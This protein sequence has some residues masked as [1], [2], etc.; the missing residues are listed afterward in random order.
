MVGSR[1]ASLVIIAT[2]VIVVGVASGAF[3]F[4]DRWLPPSQTTEGTTSG[5]PHAADRAARQNSHLPVSITLSPQAQRNLGLTT[6]PV[7]ITDAW[8]KLVVPGQLVER[9]GH[10][11]RNVTAPLT[12]VIRELFVHPNQLVH[13][14][15]LLAELELTGD[16]LATAQAD[17]LAIVRD[18][19]I[20][21][22]EQ[23]RIGKLVAEGSLPEKNRLQLEY[24]YKRLESQHQSKVQALQVLGLSPAQVEQITT[25]K[26]L[27]RTFRI[28]VPPFSSEEKSHVHDADPPA[29]AKVPEAAAH[30]GHNHAP[31]AAAPPIATVPAEPM[32]KPGHAPPMGS[33][34]Q[35]V[36]TTPAVSESQSVS[37]AH[38]HAPATAPAPVDW[39]YTVEEIHVYP[40]KRVQIGDELCSLAFHVTLFLEGQAFE[41]ESETISQ[42]MVSGSSITAE[43]QAGGKP[44]TRSGLRIVYVDNVVDPRTRTLRFY[45]PLANEV[46]H[47][48]IGP[49]GETYRTWRFKPGQRASVEVPVE[50]LPKVIVLPAAAVVREGPNAYVFRAS[51]NRFERQS[52]QIVDQSMREVTIASDGSL[53]PGETVAL[54]NAYQINLALQKSAGGGASNDHGHAHDH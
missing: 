37:S 10:S 38:E 11:H 33:S 3:Y 45:V 50:K 49:Q 21:R 17:L 53:F 23:E 9:P 42:A 22:R 39:S 24:E 27:L 29:A 12:G 14:G 7:Q 13:P 51:G 15:D 46:L 25:E 2:L 41:A 47:D 43:F 1:P 35:A 32:A 40:G 34:P 6:G 16:A 36:S 4:R 31:R 30:P 8:R 28:Y 44:I 52:V 26:Q 54:D 48:G 20:N 19:E 5:D 18:M